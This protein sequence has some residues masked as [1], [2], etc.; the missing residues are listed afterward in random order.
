MATGH[1]AMWICL[2][3]ARSTPWSCL[4]WQS[5]ANLQ[6]GAPKNTHRPFPKQQVEDTGGG[7]HPPGQLYSPQILQKPYPKV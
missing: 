1:E 6:F 4:C 7:S 2:S 5:G 3:D